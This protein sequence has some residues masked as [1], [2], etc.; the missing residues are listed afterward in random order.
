MKINPLQPPAH[1][2]KHKN[3]G[4]R[5]HL[6]LVQFLI[7]KPFKSLGAKRLQNIN[8]NV[9][10]CLYYKAFTISSKDVAYIQETLYLRACIPIKFIYTQPYFYGICM[11]CTEEI[12]ED[13]RKCI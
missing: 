3:W 9:L 12:F 2:P 8:L 7:Y 11:S 10:P 6:V 4:F 1:Q 13:N 5:L